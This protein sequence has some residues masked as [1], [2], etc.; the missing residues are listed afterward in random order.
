[1]F[2]KHKFIKTLATT[3]VIPFLCSSLFA[4]SLNPAWVEDLNF[5]LL[6]EYE[7]EVDGYEALHE[8]KL[9]G[10]NFYT[11]RAICKDGRKFDANRVGEDEDFMIQL[12]EV[13]RC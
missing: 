7:C 9:G 10:R 11:A 12:C 1:M 8:G 2:L 13:V 6:V 5:Q 3:L 4:Q